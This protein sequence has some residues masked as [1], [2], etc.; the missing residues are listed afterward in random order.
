MNDRWAIY[1]DIEG[2]SKNYE[3]STSGKNFA[4]DALVELMNSIIEI[5]SICFP[6]SIHSNYSDRLFVHQ[7]GDGFI[8]CSDFS[9]EDAT[10][11]ISIASALM[12]HMIVKGFATK[13]AIAT[14]DMIDIRGYYPEIVRASETGVINLGTG[15]M[16]TIPVMGTAILKTY[17]LSNKRSGAVLI[18]D[19]ELIKVGMSSGTKIHTNDVPCV[20]W[21]T[22]D[23]PLATEIATK[24]SLSYADSNRLFNAMELYF[25]REPNPP[26]LWVESTRETLWTNAL[27]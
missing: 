12:R 10:R 24:T 5:G 9:G 4:I 21:I 26:D 16:T 3:H 7:F 6:G 14:G 11:P 17:N 20:N 25:S 22:S 2:F 13:T 1:I 18:V 23:L 8:I 27:S 19:D 15:I